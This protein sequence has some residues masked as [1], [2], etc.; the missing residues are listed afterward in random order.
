MMK[1]ALIFTLAVL[2]VLLA[3]CGVM[4]ADEKESATQSQTVSFPAGNET[5]SGQKPT[6]AAKETETPVQT[7]EEKSSKASGSE[8][9]ETPQPTEQPKK[10]APKSEAPQSQAPKAETTQTEQKP[11]QPPAETKPVQEE[12]VSQ[13]PKEPEP[14]PTAPPEPAKPKSIYDYE[15]DVEA[16]RQELLGIGTGMGL[17]IDSSLTPDTASWGNPVT[18]SKDFQG[19]SLD[20]SLKDYVRSMPY[21]GIRRQSNSIL[22]NLCGKSR[23]RQLPL[24]LPLLIVKHTQPSVLTDRGYFFAQKYERTVFNR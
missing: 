1:K 8:I 12:T 18:A 9:E 4:P 17:T 15:F 23:R 6:E 7:E 14:E 11:T 10:E 21:H 2:V 5:V 3:G 19:T 20:R 22:H 13:S 16:I 24:L